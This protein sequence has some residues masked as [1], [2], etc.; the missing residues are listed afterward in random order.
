MVDPADG[1]VLTTVVEADAA[2]VDAAVR[3]AREAFDSGP[4]PRM[5]GR[6]RARVLHR[7]ADLIR[8]RADELVAI[9]SRDVGKPVTLCRAVDVETAAQ[10][11]E[12]CA[13]LAEGLDGRHPVD[14]R[15]PRSPTPGASRWAW[16]PRSRRS[17]S[18]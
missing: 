4:W 16:S 14:A 18:R 6:D 1:R 7:A 9:E 11:Y 13:S 2:D 15:S 8:E 5:R 10:Q 17:T 12:Y 3:A